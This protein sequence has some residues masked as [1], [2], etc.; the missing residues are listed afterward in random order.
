MAKSQVSLGW[1]K[2]N[3]STL[4]QRFPRYVKMSS[5]YCATLELVYKK[6]WQPD[7]IFKP[8]IFCVSPKRGRGSANPL[9]EDLSASWKLQTCTL[10]LAQDLNYFCIHK[11]TDGAWVTRA[12][13]KCY[14]RARQTCANGI[15]V[16][17]I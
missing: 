1:T 11:C 8:I 10:N 4:L 14:P 16:D 2:C 3:R 6:K 12:R 9:T 13:Q 15:G 17:C 7:C 5:S